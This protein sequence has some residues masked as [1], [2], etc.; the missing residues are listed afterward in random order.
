MKNSPG[1]ACGAKQYLSSNKRQNEY[2][3]FRVKSFFFFLLISR[4]VF[5]SNTYPTRN[6]EARRE[7]YPSFG[8]R[9]PR[10]VS[11]KLQLWNTHTHTHT[12]THSDLN[13]LS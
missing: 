5:V 12:G 8:A 7:T 3:T 4:L 13:D 9:S 2:Y 1:S 11:L 10:R 6:V